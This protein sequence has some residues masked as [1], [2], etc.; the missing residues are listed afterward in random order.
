MIRKL[1]E[2]TNSP[3]PTIPCDC[4]DDEEVVSATTEPFTL[5]DIVLQ[6]EQFFLDG[7]DGGQSD[8]RFEW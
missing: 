7:G 4:P 3:A 8:L 1:E 6:Q 5:E 2:E